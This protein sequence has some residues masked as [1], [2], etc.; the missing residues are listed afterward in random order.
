MEFKPYPK[1]PRLR[2]TIVITEKIDGTNAQIQ[3]DEH[4]DILVGSRKRQIFPEGTVRDPNRLD[5]YVKATDNFGFAHWAYDNKEALFE[6]LGEG[7][8]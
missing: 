3:F 7:C 8:H 4:G 1:T 2:R 6:F 5:K